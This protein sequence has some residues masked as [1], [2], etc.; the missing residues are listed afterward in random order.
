MQKNPLQN[1]WAAPQESNLLEWHFVV[2][3]QPGTPYS[4]GWYHGI[5]LFPKDYPYKPPGLQMLT[6]NGRFKVGF[7]I[8]IA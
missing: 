2:E 7:A 8:G 4:G 5:I 6:P 3:G 1:I